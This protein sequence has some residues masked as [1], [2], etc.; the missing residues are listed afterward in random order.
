MNQIF[1][2]ER[3]VGVIGAPM[4]IGP[5]PPPAVLDFRRIT[6][7]KIHRPLESAAFRFGAALLG[8]CLSACSTSSSPGGGGP[9]DATF[10]GSLEEA[11]SSDGAQD[12]SLADAS[13]P[14]SNAGDAT[15]PDATEDAA[16]PADGRV[17]A[18]GD[19]P[20][21]APSES[22]VAD[23][24]AAAAETTYT[25]IAAL[26]GQACL[27]CANDQN[28]GACLSTDDLDCESLGTATA[29]GGPDAGA[30][31]IAALSRHA[32]LRAH[33][34]LHGRHRCGRPG[35]RRGLLLRPCHL[36]R[37]H[38]D[39]L[40][41]R[42][43]VHRGDG[44]RDH[45]SGDHLPAVPRF[46]LR[47][48]NGQH[49]RALPPSRAARPAFPATEPPR[50]DRLEDGESRRGRAIGSKTER[51]AEDAESPSAASGPA[52][53]PRRT[54][55]DTNQKKGAKRGSSLRPQS[56]RLC[57]SLESQGPVS[58]RSLRTRR[59]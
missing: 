55:G 10:D 9:A 26:R 58:P 49:D 32:A 39:A 24:D 23:A 43:Q 3:N 36:R 51:A 20:V 25:I 11:A 48:G 5:K 21:D 13:L 19:A 4:E 6:A 52:R 7:L 41:G 31:R 37:V 16:L 17:D 15:L 59:R 34:R 50:R 12:A 47:R 54:G 22:E 35:Q 18:P 57:G 27:D 53:A 38:V 33:H 56:L 45:R 42:L 8:F 29:D 40:P 30:S 28:M 1:N 2:A 46:R 44:P 14:D